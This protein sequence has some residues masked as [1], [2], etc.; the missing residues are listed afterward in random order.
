[1]NKAIEPLIK[2]LEIIKKDLEFNNIS[3][4]EASSKLEVIISEYKNIDLTPDNWAAEF[5]SFLRLP[6][7]QKHL[8]ELFNVYLQSNH[9]DDNRDRNTKLY[10]HNQIQELLII[11][12]KA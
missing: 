2:S 1:M 4:S 7:A 11:L 10:M 9:A 5:F 3:K 6:E 12:D 8:K